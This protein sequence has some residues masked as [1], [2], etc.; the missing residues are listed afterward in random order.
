M[1]FRKAL[2]TQTSILDVHTFSLTFDFFQ[3]RKACYNP[4][5]TVL[6]GVG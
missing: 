1:I 3:I 6:C 5:L 2:L 4:I